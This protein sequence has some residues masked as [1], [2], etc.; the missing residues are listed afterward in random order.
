M[1]RRRIKVGADPFPPYQYYDDNKVL[2]GLDYDKVLAVFYEASYEID[3]TLEDWSIIQNQLD[4]GILDAAFQVQPTTDRLDKYYFS[5]VLR[6]ASTEVVTSRDDIH[7]DSYKQIETLDLK[8]GV[9]TGYTNGADI[10]A[11]NDEVKY[12]YPNP[13]ALI[14]AISNNEVDVAVFDRGVKKYLMDENGISNIVS[15]DSMT[16]LR[17]LHV[18][19]TDE[20]LRDEFDAAMIRLGE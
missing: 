15:I 9:I 19:F 13:K 3:V 7:I 14:I 10:D 8:L 18:I 2:K 17:P 1:E 5:N 16:F 4:K 6:E 11:L 12:A 20:T